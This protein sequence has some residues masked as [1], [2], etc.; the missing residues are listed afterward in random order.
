VTTTRRALAITLWAGPLLL[1]ILTLSLGAGRPGQSPVE[2]V[3]RIEIR[4]IENTFRL[5]PQLYSGGDP[6]GAE[7]LA[8]LKMLGIRTIISVDGV[9]PDVETA[10]GLGIRYVHLPIGYDGVPR[11]QAVR[12]V[13]AV[14]TLPGPVYVHCH[15]GIHRGPAAAAICG[16]ASEG[17]SKKQAADWMEQAG[18]SADYRGLYASVR[19][20]AQPTGKELEAVGDELP[21]SSE[22][23]ALVE[24][25]VKVDERW[26]IIKAIQK[27]GFKPPARHPDVVST[28]ES[29][30]LLELFRESSR[31]PESK[32]KAGDFLDELAS[33]ER[34]AS[35]L[36]EAMAKY[37]KQASP[38][39]LAELEA[40]FT[41][42]GKSCKSCHM[43][44]RDNRPD[45]E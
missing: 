44:S 1:G 36:Y 20:F 12:L 37:E 45:A 10:K 4:G 29:L 28:A 8:A 15:H 16:M 31:L 22:V 21:E 34:L 17:W 6:H 35:G 38:E 5:S 11:D 24:M 14:K 32:E 41:A 42:V 9:A 39:S 23:P 19:D 40:A 25:M 13:K 2:A 3:E 18:T 43:R 26:D 7:A 30:Q 27:A 33:A